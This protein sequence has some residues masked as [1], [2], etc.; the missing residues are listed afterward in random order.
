MVP[1]VKDDNAQIEANPATEGQSKHLRYLYVSAPRIALCWPV[2]KI[3]P[4]VF[5]KSILSHFLEVL[6]RQPNPYKSTL[7]S[8]ASALICYFSPLDSVLEPV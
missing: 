4:F 8:C 2:C 5:H 6:Q 1:G 3:Y 7:A